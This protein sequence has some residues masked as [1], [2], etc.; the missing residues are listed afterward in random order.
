M[1]SYKDILNKLKILDITRDILIKYNRISKIPYHNFS[2][3]HNKIKKSLT[4][5]L[6]NVLNL[7]SEYELWL[8]VKKFEKEFAKYCGTKYAI[9][10]SSGTAALQ[11]S[12]LALNI[13]ERDEVITVPNSYIATALSISNTGAKPVFVDINPDTYNI[14]V[15]KI[16][17]KITDKTKAILPVHLYG[18]SVDLDSINKIAKKYNLKVIEDAC[19]ACGGRYKNKRLGSV[20]D[21]G[22]F[23]FYTSKN[24]GGLGNGGMV[25][26]NDKM[27][28]E[29]IRQLKNPESNDRFL[30]KSKRT[31]AYL[32]AIQVAVLKAKLPF[33]EEHI[34]LKQNNA[35]LYNEFLR[36]RC[37]ILPKEEDYSSHSYYSYVIQ[38][39]KRDKLKKYLSRRNIETRIEYKI[40]IHLTR[41]YEYLGHKLGDFPLTEKISKQILSL[42]IGIHL[43]TKDIHYISKNIKKFIRKYG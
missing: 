21:I 32:D 18:Q 36:G 35:K 4:K 23:S 31:P 26:S 30:T 5:E 29:K 3:Q 15:C 13:K 14:D 11:F 22:C 17:E 16:E 9:G 42:P 33:L 8:Y 40:P 19:Q 12:L 41:A 24:L 25:V 10:T 6:N 27:I 1:Y 38:T 37:I 43:F 7:S 2:Y 39:K 28:I 20:C 34:K